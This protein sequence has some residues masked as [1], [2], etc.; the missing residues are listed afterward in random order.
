M[1]M[2]TLYPYLMLACILGMLASCKKETV[3][4]TGAT[5]TVSSTTLATSGSIA[6]ASVT[7]ST[8]SVYL[9]NCYPGDE[10][11]DTVAF[12]AL[13]SG[14][15]TYL[16]SNYS[17]YKLKHVFGILDT[18]KTVKA[19]IVVIKY[20]GSFVGLKFTAT[21]TFVKVLEQME[22]HDRGGKGWHAGGPF[23][24][25]DGQ[26]R[27]T[28]SL[29]AIPSVVLTYFTTHYPSDT[30]LHASTTPDTNYILVSKDKV[31][32]ATMISKSGSL[33]K[34]ISLDAKPG[35][36]PAA[37]AQSALPAA[38]TTYLT[39]TYP[40]YVFNKAFADVDNGT[41]EVYHVFITANNTNYVVDFDGAGNFKKAI[42]LH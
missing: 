20:N 18:T 14:I 28:I 36:P 22:G 40:G 21:G 9:V 8:D 26:G 4:T 19:Y 2:K 34:R 13:P 35:P 32:Y 5:K 31:L 11:K 41:V 6:L 10:H 12:S 30:L 1:K 37:I 15:S 17:G 38:I 24:D 39:T 16:D 7:G 29:S 33:L 25:R 27:D 23:G 42:V 3:T